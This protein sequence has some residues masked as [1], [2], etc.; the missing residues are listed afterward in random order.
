MALPRLRSFGL[1]FAVALAAP[2][3]AEGPIPE[4][5]WGAVEGGVYRSTDDSYFFGDY[6]GIKDDAWYGLANVEL[7]GRAA[8]DSGETW[9]FDLQGSNLALDSRYIALAGGIQ[10]LFDAYVEW[11]QIP[12]FDDDTA[13]LA[14][15]GR[16]TD[17]L[18]LPPGWVPGTT[19]AGF[20]ALDG[21]LQRLNLY[22]QRNALRA[23]VGVVLPRGLSFA[24]DYEWE[25][26]T[27]RYVVGAVIGNSG[28]NPRTALLPERRNWQTHE[29]DSKLRFANE[30]AQLE[31]GYQNS[32]FDDFDDSLTWQNPYAAIGGWNPAAGYPSGFGRK[33]LAPDNRFHQVY[34][35]GGYSL[36]WWRTR[37][38]GQA[39]F[40]WYRQDDD[41][42]PYTVNPAL[43]V[44][45]P[46]P[47]GDADAAI[48]ATHVLLRATSR[49]LDK[50]RLTASYRFDDRDNDTPRDVYIYVPGDSLDQEGIDSA[51][52]RMNLPNS[53]RL[54][55]G[56]IDVAY[57]IWRRTE[58]SAGYEHQ[59]EIRSWTETDQLDDDVFR[60]GLRTRAL[61]WADFRVDATYWRRDAG[62][63]FYQAP[64]VWGFSP[65]HVATVPSDQRFENLPALRKFSYTDRDR[66]AVD[67]RLVV[68][69]FDAAA[70]GFS[71][72][73][74]VDSYDGSELGLRQRDALR[75][76]VDASWSPTETVTAYLWYQNDD[77]RSD[78]RGRQWTG[79]G[80]AFDSSF[81]WKNEDRDEI[82][83]VGLG[84]EW[85]GFEERLRLRADYAFSWAKERVNT[86]ANPG[87]PPTRPFPDARTLM[88]DVGFSAEIGIR[89]GLTGR[90]GYLF[91]FL[92]VNDWA[93]DDVGPA[94]VS[95]VLGLGQSMPDHAAHL[96]AFSIEYRF[97]FGIER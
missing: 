74:A 18:T 60:A 45:T 78:V 52:A 22:R 15:L 31:I 68:M 50:L 80:D 85:S 92:D 21:A 77:Y 25:R 70:I 48:D 36:P 44:T 83:T 2:A 88:H 26:R 5:I 19:T 47:H 64:A 1:A 79:L 86:V 41:F 67:A 81:D 33:G 35:S 84:A 61:R 91:Q 8:W 63:Y 38:A 71:L 66:G 12:R 93:Y 39:S 29:S 16:G 90:F 42:L 62:D 43:S 56:R 40:A 89:E 69:P 3:A 49:P 58:L 53:Y 59:R 54:H 30:T 72:G 11:D 97:A 57:E 65:Q 27:G 34:G 4:T 10:G 6:T 94:T 32:F 7:H 87:L 23:G 75:W 13:S 82:Q 20:A 46:L 76:G 37:I 73:W 51:R 24:S 96:F 14:F 9:H 17:L 95:E 55:E 28:G